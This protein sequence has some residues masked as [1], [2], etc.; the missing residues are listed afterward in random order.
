MPALALGEDEAEALALGLRVVASMGDAGLAEAARGLLARLPPVVTPGSARRLRGSGLV[1]PPGPAQE[2][3]PAALASFRRA[4]RE[5]RKLRLAYVDR[6]GARTSRVVRPLSIAFFP[7]DW[8]S[9]VWC[10]LRGDFRSL[11]LGRIESLAV[12]DERFV[13]EPGRRF[14]DW[15]AT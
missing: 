13:P 12:L 10:E 9:A 11:H 14:E 6:S 4:L 3:A 1:A 15:L 7:P 5:S 8:M 2:P